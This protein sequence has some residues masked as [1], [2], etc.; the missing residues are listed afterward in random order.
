M[1]WTSA[2]TLYKP[3]LNSTYEG[4]VAYLT[5]YIDQFTNSTAAATIYNSQNGSAI[6]CSG[7]YGKIQL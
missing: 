5:I 6:E 2:A 4:N 7:I 3:A 1:K